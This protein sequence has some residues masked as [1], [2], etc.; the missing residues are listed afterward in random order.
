MQVALT[1]SDDEDVLDYQ[2]SRWKDEAHMENLD[3]LVRPKQTYFVQL[4]R[5]TKP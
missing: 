1:N 2:P 5:K 4:Y 3:K